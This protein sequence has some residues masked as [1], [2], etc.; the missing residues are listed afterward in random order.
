MD[1]IVCHVNADFDCLGAL[2]GAAR[3]Y[4]GAVM[5]LPGGEAPGVRAFLSLHREV[6]APRVP[7]EVDPGTLTRV[8]V[9]DTNTRKRLGPAADWLDLPDLEVH[10]YDHH[11]GQ[12]DI[13]PVRQWVAGVG[14]VSSLVA[15]ELRAR[16]EKL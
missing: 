7:A 16:G 1:V 13:A 5:V 12:G 4:P 15:A 11:P 3:L 2:V 10:L 14:A 6:F 9:V 8:V